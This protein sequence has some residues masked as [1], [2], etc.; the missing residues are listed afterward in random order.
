MCCA[1]GQPGR[2]ACALWKAVEAGGFSARR[3]VLQAGAG[4]EVSRHGA[5]SFSCWKS[6][7]SERGCVKGVSWRLFARLLVRLHHLPGWPCQLAHLLGKFK[8][9]YRNLTR[10]LSSSINLL[11]SPHLLSTCSLAHSSRQHHPACIAAGWQ[12]LCHL[13]KSCF[14]ACYFVDCHFLLSNVVFLYMYMF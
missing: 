9:A 10:N 12:Q 5:L 14:R 2:A 8:E 11:V 13:P 3:A 1:R 7:R 4:V 6:C